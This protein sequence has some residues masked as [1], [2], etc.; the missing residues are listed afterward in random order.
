MVSTEVVVAVALTKVIEAVV[1]VA[2]DSN[3]ED[4]LEAR[5]K[6]LNLKVNTISTKPMKN[7]KKC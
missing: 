5:K 3:P 6:P 2:E 4:L 7:S 1:A